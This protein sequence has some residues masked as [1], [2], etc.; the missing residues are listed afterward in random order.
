MRTGSPATA[1][2]VLTST[3]SAPI[4]IAAAACDGAPSPASTTTGTLLCSMMI[5][6][7]SRVTRPLF[8]PIGAAR[9]ITVAAPASSRRLHNTG[10]AWM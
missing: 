10:S 7:S 9:G 4:S 8:V 2:A 1:M 5:S 3:A 6:S